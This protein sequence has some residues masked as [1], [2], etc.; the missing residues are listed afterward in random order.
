MTRVY[1]PQIQYISVFA[2]SL[3]Y[4]GL[5]NIRIYVVN[6]DK[7]TDI[8]LFNSTID[9]I[10]NFVFQKDYITLLDLGTPPV[11]TDYGYG[12]TDR[13]LSHLY[14]QYTEYSSLCQYL[15]V[16]NGD[17][18]YSRNFG[19]KIVQHMKA[20]MDIIAWGFVSHH[21][22]PHQQETIDEKKNVVPKIADDGT[23]KCIPVQLQSEMIDLGAAAYRFGFLYQHRLLFAQPGSP[24][25]SASDGTF[26]EK[27][28]KLT[29]ASVLLRQTLLMHQ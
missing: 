11:V 17:N 15:M 25:A 8:Q 22:K 20:K 7:R 9:F 23:Q 21:F 2:L 28:A 16:T 26:V 14:E 18:L 24:Y 12:M 3:R 19:K 6:T 10:N 27:L 4:S 1:G 5:D 13:A 29:N